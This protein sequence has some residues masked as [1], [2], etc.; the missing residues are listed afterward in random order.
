MKVF[1]S[2]LALGLW[3]CLQVNLCCVFLCT[4]ELACIVFMCVLV[5]LL[6]LCLCVCLRVRLHCVY[7]CVCEFACIVFIN[8]FASLL[9]LCLWVCLRARLLAEKEANYLHR[10]LAPLSTRFGCDWEATI[11]KREFI[12]LSNWIWYEYM[13]ALL[14]PSQNELPSFDPEFCTWFQ[15]SLIQIYL[16]PSPISTLS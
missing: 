8:V 7:K 6:A 16:T 9:A 14:I 10:I 12:M 5:S 11:V 13:A 1:V 2:L 4:C 3:V 15:G